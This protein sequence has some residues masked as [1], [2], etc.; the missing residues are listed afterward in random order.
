MSDSLDTV[1][2]VAEGG[3]DTTVRPCDLSR[4]K[5]LDSYSIEPEKLATVKQAAIRLGRSKADLIREGVDLVL[6]KYRDKLGDLASARPPADAP[7]PQNGPSA[8]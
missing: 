5:I 1:L 6:E 3:G 7:K 4:R 2:I 8:S